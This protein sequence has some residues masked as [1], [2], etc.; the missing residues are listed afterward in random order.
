MVGLYQDN[1]WAQFATS[2]ISKT[3][4]SNLKKKKLNIY[5]GC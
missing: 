2:L 1:S 5:S 4:G 3:T